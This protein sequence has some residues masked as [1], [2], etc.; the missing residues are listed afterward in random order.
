MIQSEKEFREQFDL[1]SEKHH[2]GSTQAVPLGGARIPTS[3][4][5]EYPENFNP[6]E[7]GPT[8]EELGEEYIRLEK[9]REVLTGMKKILAKQAQLT[10]AV[11]RHNEH[12]REKGD[13]TNPQHV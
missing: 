13:K 7:T 12:F 5:Q 10:E 2:K 6:N 4:P 11:F 8:R 3:M 1:N 9:Q